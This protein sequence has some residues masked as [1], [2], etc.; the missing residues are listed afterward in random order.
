MVRQGTSPVE[1]LRNTAIQSFAHCAL[2]RLDCFRT[3]TLRVEGGRI[4]VEDDRQSTHLES[5]SGPRTVE[6]P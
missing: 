6:Q 2:I 5:A 1:I 3:V 4:R